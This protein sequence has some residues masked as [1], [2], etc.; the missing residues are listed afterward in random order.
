MRIS[1]DLDD[2]LICYQPDVPH[3]PRLAW[4]QRVFVGDEPL[5]LGSRSLVRQLR[6]Q[7][8]EIWIYTTSY[9]RPA[10]IRRW[11]WCHGIRVTNVINQDVYDA[12]LKKVPQ[13]RPPTKNPKA[14][15]IDLHIDDL[16]GVRLEG[17]T[18][19]FRVLVIRPDDEAW[20]NKVWT[21]TEEFRRRTAGPQRPTVAPGACG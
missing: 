1:F 14:F 11:L 8:W 18:H 10:H 9:R 19:G 21:T 20:A 17:E 13:H 6:E 5:R 15:G 2:T 4:Y 3:E 16:E 12:H 7:G